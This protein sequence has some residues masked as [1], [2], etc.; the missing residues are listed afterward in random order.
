MHNE[1]IIQIN[2]EYPTKQT[3]QNSDGLNEFENGQNFYQI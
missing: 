2:A 3:N 1:N